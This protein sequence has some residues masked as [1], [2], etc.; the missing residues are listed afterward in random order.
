MTKSA[1][2][3]AIALCAGTPATAAEQHPTKLVLE[4]AAM[5]ALAERL[6]A[7]G[8]AADAE[9]LLKAL[10]GDPDGELRAEARYQLAQLLQRRGASRA[11]AVELRRLADEKP[12]AANVRLALA[13]LLA[14]LG[15]GEAAR[16]ELR[17]LGSARLPG[18]VAAFVD[19]FEARL[20][21]SRP[22]GASV[23]LAIAP[24]SNINR[25]T[26]SDTLGTVIGDFTVDED[27]KARS[28]VGLAV[29]ANA[30][31]RLGVSDTVNVLVRAATRADLYRESE[32]NDVA[33]DLSAG[34]EF[35]LGRGRAGV[36]TG[37]SGRWFGQKPF[38]RAARI[39]AFWALPLGSRTQIRLE[40]SAAEIDNR[41]NAIQSGK[42]LSLQGTLERALS[43]T[44]GV[45]LSLGTDRMKARDPGYSTT[46][47]RAA[48]AVRRDLARAT[49]TAGVE[50]GR[51][52]ADERLLLLPK[53]RS[54]RLTRVS[55]GATF[56]QLGIAGFAPTARLVWERNRSS[57]ELYEYSRRRIEIGIVRGF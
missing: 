14:D 3:A 45:A 11:A 27:G 35:R 25:A 38:L 18:E 39:G 28:G 19:R 30:Y 37:L 22:W 29:G 40:G 49:V 20:R 12:A 50:L 53:K 34:P 46:G 57:V 5:L 41:R 8:R 56:R 51:L 6:E 26:R 44:T 9:R 24:D 4:P 55:L 15:D 54:D 48:L 2:L 52:R 10:L 36:A 1:W 43:P 7:A 13:R 23:E 21:E 47:L 16:R 42:A 33:V 32:F 31:R 17:A